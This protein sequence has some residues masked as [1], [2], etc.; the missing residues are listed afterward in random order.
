M[1]S[2]SENTKPIAYLY[3]TRTNLMFIA[4]SQ[5]KYSFFSANKRMEIRK[6]YIDS[7]K[8]GWITSSKEAYELRRTN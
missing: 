3:N 1:T 5:D 2:F 4:Y 8:S 6:C 7:L